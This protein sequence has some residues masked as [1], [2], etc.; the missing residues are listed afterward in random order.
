MVIDDLTPLNGHRAAI[1][2]LSSFNTSA[3]QRLIDGLLQ[4][5]RLALGP[6]RREGRFVK[7]SADGRYVPLIIDTGTHR[8]L[9]TAWAAQRLGCTE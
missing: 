8:P 5:Q 9:P 6:C 3:V 1:S 2:A 4:S 7:L